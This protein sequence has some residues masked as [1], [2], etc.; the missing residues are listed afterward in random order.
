MSSPSHNQHDPAESGFTLLEILVVTLVFGLLATALWEGI[1]VGTH[2]WASQQKF[3]ESSTE[4]VDMETALRRVIARAEP[5]DNDL[6]P[7]FGGLTDRLRLISWLPENGGY[8]HD[9]EAGLG[10]NAQHQLILRWRPFRRARCATDDPAFHEEIL[11]RNVRAITFSYYGRKEEIH[12]WQESWNQPGLPFLVK[13]HVDFMR[14]DLNWP[15]IYIRPL[16]AGTES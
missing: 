11:A 12:G 5:T 15:D 7:A 14:T 13:L 1:S 8:K 10:L 6:P 16:M 3:Y 4:L 2:G 9:I